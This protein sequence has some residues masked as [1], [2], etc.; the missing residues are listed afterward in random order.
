MWSILIA[1]SLIGC[2]FVAERLLRQGDLAR[3]FKRGQADQ[4]STRVVGAA[5]GL[6]LLASPERCTELMQERK[7]PKH[8]G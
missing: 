5:F 4:G 7:H 6:A 3:S 2:F 1:Y 8:S